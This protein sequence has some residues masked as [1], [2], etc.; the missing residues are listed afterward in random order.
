VEAYSSKRRGR[1]DR[2]RC[3]G[4]D[5]LDLPGPHER[6]RR[7]TDAAPIPAMTQK[8]SANPLV[9]ALSASWPDAMSVFVWVNATVAAIATPSAPP[10][11]CDVLIKPDARPASRSGTPA[12]AAIDIGMNENAIPIPTSRYPGNRSMR[13]CRAR[14]SACTRACRR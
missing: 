6:E 8:P 4:L 3:L 13:S 5:R 11:C 10:I 9:C 12:S 7:A 1:L 14:G 2:L